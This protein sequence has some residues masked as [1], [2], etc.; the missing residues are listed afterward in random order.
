MHPEGYRC[1]TLYI[2]YALYIHLFLYVTTELWHGV[3][4]KS[5]IQRQIWR[6]FFFLAQSSYENIKEAFEFKFRKSSTTIFS[7]D[8]FKSLFYSNLNI[9]YLNRIIRRN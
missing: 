3:S 1:E 9:F 8:Y 6:R 5:Q 2:F 4:K 7:S